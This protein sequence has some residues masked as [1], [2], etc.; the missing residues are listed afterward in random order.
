MGGDIGLEDG[1]SLGKACNILS[2]DVV[3]DRFGH[4]LNQWEAGISVVSGSEK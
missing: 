1:A 2:M 4:D 3:C